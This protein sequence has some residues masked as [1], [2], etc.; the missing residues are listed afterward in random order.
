MIEADGQVAGLLKG[1]G[2]GF[3]LAKTGLA[4]R[5]LAGVDAFLV[6]SSSRGHGRS[7][8]PRRDRRPAWRRMLRFRRRGRA[9]GLGRPYIMSILMLSTPARRRPA[10]AVSMESRGCMRLMRRCTSCVE[11]LDAEAR[12]AESVAGKGADDIERKAAGIRFGCDLGIAG[13]RKTAAKRCE[14]PINLRRC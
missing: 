13:E 5:Q 7:Q 4:F 2:G 3:G 6:L 10:M 1:A 11:H 9:S 8:K 14:Q 12:A